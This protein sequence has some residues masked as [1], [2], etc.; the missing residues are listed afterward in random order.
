M[1]PLVQGED[2][3]L[4]LTQPKSRSETQ[5]LCRLRGRPQLHLRFFV[6]IPGNTFLQFAPAVS[7]PL[8]LIFLVGFLNNFLLFHFS[9]LFLPSSLA[10]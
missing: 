2:S 4:W 9:S 8:V 6:L 3:F 10:S 1:E 5:R 7:G